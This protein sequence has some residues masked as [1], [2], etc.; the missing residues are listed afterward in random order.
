MRETTSSATPGTEGNRSNN[1]NT[2][3]S[4]SKTE[5]ESNV[6]NG[7]TA[8]N[9]MLL[10]DDGL[11]SSC[12]R[13][14]NGVYG[15]VYTAKLGSDVV[16]IKRNTVHQSLSGIGSLKEIDILQK[17]RHPF[18]VSLDAISTDQIDIDYHEANISRLEEAGIEIDEDEMTM[19]DYKEDTVSLIF[20]RADMTLDSLAMKYSLSFPI[21][22]KIITQILL[23]VEYMHDHRVIH[24]DLKPENI[25]CRLPRQKNAKLDLDELEIA[26]CDFG[27]SE[28]WS[29]YDIQDMEVVTPFYR[30]PEIAPSRQ[31]YDKKIDVWSVGC[32]VYELFA[33]KALSEATQAFRRL[34]RDKNQWIAHL[35]KLEL[36]LTEPQLS[37]I[38]DVL[39]GSLRKSPTSRSTAREL[40]TLSFFSEE[41]ELIET[42]R[43]KT[44]RQDSYKT[45]Y[46]V[47]NS[48][49]RKAFF[50]MLKH[51]QADED[52]KNYSWYSDRLLFSAAS[53]FDR[54]TS[55][56]DV[57]TILYEREFFMTILYVA[58]KF[59]TEQ[60]HASPDEIMENATGNSLS[61]MLGYEMFIV[62]DVLNFR[63]SSSTLY[64]RIS[65]AENPRNLVEKGLDVL[66]S[67]SDGSYT[68]E[69]IYR[70]HIEPIIEDRKTNRTKTQKRT[71]RQTTRRTTRRK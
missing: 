14:A 37:M 4:M 57:S 51:I 15:R 49:L 17:V 20:E 45:E 13:L 60:Y 33:G 1:T 35:K 16:I 19:E 32:I 9:F 34:P 38:A 41:S 3:Q 66:A 7:P 21:M 25:L 67:L 71:T 2:R 8:G 29:K 18:I 12:A 65:D 36:S 47:S 70:N 24:R 27:M 40:L 42:I 63:I 50:A 22:R 5:E 48:P 26:I 53:L 23:A 30:A 55:I 31:H 11:L 61:C 64:D 56:V 52:L 44:A 59:H 54:V 6:G 28:Y 62:A 39:V 43:S 46:A 58:A 69:E 68:V 10:L